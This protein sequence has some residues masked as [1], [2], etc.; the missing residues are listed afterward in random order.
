MEELT[1]VEEFKELEHGDKVYILNQID[2]EGFRF[3]GTM[4]NCDNYYIFSHGE[5]LIH[6]HES[7]IGEGSLSRSR[8][9]KGEYSSKFI[10]GLMIESLVKKIKQIQDI[11]LKD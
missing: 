2:C 6:V 4:P 10:G 11:Y 1:T 3:V 9:F 8:Y 7:R 5:K